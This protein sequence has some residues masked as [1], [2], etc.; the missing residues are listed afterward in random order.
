MNRVLLLCLCAGLVVVVHLDYSGSHLPA[1]LLGMAIT[2]GTVL[3]VAAA[4][5]SNAKWIA[6]IKRPLLALA[7]LLFLFPFLVQLGPYPWLEHPTSWL[8]RDFFMVR[9]VAALL[10]LAVVGVCFRR[11]S[12]RESAAVGKWAVAY[13]LTFVVVKTLVAVDWVM[14]FDYPWV[15][16]MF[17][18]IYMIECFYAGLALAGIV[19]LV[20]ERRLPKSMDDGT[21]YDTASLLFGFA[22]FWGGLTFAQYLTIWYGNIPEEVQFFTRRFAL[23]GGRELFAG[24]IVLLFVIP[25]TAFLVHRARTNS[26][27]VAALALSILIGLVAARLFH[28][29]PYVQFN[30]GLFLLEF[31]AMMVVIAATVHPHLP[32]R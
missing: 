6:P 2:Q 24:S 14:S 30:A 12:L 28:L 18:A 31:F 11:A 7:P 23:L 20:R 26:L 4:T 9:N 27:A 17:P 21:V 19:C 16:T 1:I 5:V 15:S 13:I 8:R 22:L 10:V 25:F 32:D 29:L 3:V